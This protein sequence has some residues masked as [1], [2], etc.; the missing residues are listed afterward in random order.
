[1][2]LMPSPGKPKILWMP[3]SARRET[4]KSLT[5]AAMMLSLLDIAV[6]ERLRASRPASGWMR[7]QIEEFNGDGRLK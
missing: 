3:H 4:R 7:T 1:M 2:P 5:L 6:A